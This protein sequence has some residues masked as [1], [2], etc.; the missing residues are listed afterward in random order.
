VSGLPPRRSAGPPGPGEDGSLLAELV[1][2]A[3]LLLVGVLLV[4]LTLG[5]P[6]RGMER[7]ATPAEGFEGIDRAGLEFVSAVRTARP[8]LTRPAVLDAGPRRLVLALDHLHR[9][10]RGD[11]TWSVELVGDTLVTHESSSLGSTE[12]RVVLR[13]VH[14]DRSGLRYLDAEHRELESAGGLAPAALARIRSIE[15]HVVVV[16]PA[17]GVLEVAVTHRASLRLVGPLA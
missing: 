15:L 2:A 4:G 9:D 10:E 5:G 7:V 3:G 17:T 13:H 12:S 11:R 8:A 6:I 14:Q 1:V 16:D